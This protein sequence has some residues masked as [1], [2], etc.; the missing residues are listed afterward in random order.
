MKDNTIKILS[1]GRSNQKP[2][3][4][5][6]QKIITDFYGDENKDMIFT[7]SAFESSKDYGS[8]FYV[9]LAPWTC[10][11]CKFSKSQTTIDASWAIPYE[12]NKG[13]NEK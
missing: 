13:K 3:L 2:V 1:I 8:G 7:V 6:G 4:K 5:V 9:T 12:E 11:C 10:P